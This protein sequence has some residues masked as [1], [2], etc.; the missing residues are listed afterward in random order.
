MLLNLY[1][2]LKYNHIKGSS[3]KS[4]ALAKQIIEEENLEDA[5]DVGKFVDDKMTYAMDNFFGIIDVMQDLD[6]T[7]KRGYKG[8]CDD[9][10]MLAYRL[11]EQLDYEP[12][13]MTIVPL[14][15][16]VSHVICTFEMNGLIYFISTNGT[17]AIGGFED[18]QQIFD[19]LDYKRVLA[20][21][22]RQVV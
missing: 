15:I 6:Y 20:Y 21:N 3:E 8:D 9:F 14:N 13:L 18:I 10:S 5:Y 17:T 2:K 16:T 7:V 19:Y 4:T 11:L 12:Q 22:V 1:L